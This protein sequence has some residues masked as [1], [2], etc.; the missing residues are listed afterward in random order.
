MTHYLRRTILVL[1]IGSLGALAA[2]LLNLAIG[3]GQPERLLI[4]VGILCEVSGIVQFIGSM[5]F[6][7]MLRTYSDVTKYPYGPPS[8]MMRRVV[9]DPDAPKSVRVEDALTQKPWIGGG[10]FAIG[11]LL[12]LVTLWPRT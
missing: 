2:A 5:R 9:D 3:G 10:V 1:V 4:A 8:H 6:V 11:M 12:H 7:A